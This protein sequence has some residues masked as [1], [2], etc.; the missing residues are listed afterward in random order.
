MQKVV[1]VETQFFQALQQTNHTRLQ[2]GLHQARY[3]P[4]EYTGLTYFLS[5][6]SKKMGTSL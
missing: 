5:R 4:H 3:T 6:I 2:H 1:A